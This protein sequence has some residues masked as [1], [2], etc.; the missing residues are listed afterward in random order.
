MVHVT[1]QHRRL[2]K[3]LAERAKRAEV[4]K[5]TQKHN[6]CHD[7]DFENGTLDFDPVFFNRKDIACKCIEKYQICQNNSGSGPDPVIPNTGNPGHGCASARQLGRVTQTHRETVLVRNTARH[8]G[9]M[10]AGRTCPFPFLKPKK[11]FGCTFPLPPPPRLWKNSGWDGWNM[12]VRVCQ[13]S[14]NAEKHGETVSHGWKLVWTCF[15]E[16]FY[17]TFLALR[18]WLDLTK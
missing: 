9:A 14:H 4:Y 16:L 15:K 7:D 10:G 6:L 3:F 5:L 17:F 12:G 13:T 8:N 18:I 1:C 11:Y 2:I